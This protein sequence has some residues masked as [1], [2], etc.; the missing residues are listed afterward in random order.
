[1]WEHA[2][3]LKGG[4]LVHETMLRFLDTWSDEGMPINPSLDEIEK[5]GARTPGIAA[6]MYS[7]YID[8]RASILRDAKLLSNEKPFAVP[9]PYINDTW[10]VG[11]LDKA[12]EYNGN[13]LVIEHKTTSEYS[14][15]YSFQPNYVESWDVSPQIKGYQYG[16]TLTYGSIDA[17]WIDAALVHKKI[18]NAFTFI[19]IAHH[20][21]LLKGWILNTN[22]WIQSIEYDRAVLNEQEG[23]L[24]NRCFRVNEESCYGRYGP[25]PFL[26]ICRT[27][28]DPSAL[29]SAPNGYVED[30]WEPF[31]ILKL[32]ELIQ[33]EK[34]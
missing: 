11:R 24:E 8:A 19:P 2:N 23:R 22:N 28:D 5:L 33:E 17:V 29:K 1:M 7:N 3:E 6:E 34:K 12:V 16:G 18:H 30:R 27:T 13:R 4:D 10:Y 21:V 9:M 14:I 15:K 32:N 25:C 31:D 20:S 26:E